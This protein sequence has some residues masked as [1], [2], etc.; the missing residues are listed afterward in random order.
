MNNFNSNFFQAVVCFVAS[1]VFSA[2][3]LT[4]AVQSSL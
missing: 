4:L 1:F 2:V 3:F